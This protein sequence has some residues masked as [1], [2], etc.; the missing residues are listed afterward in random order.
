MMIL[1]LKK[2]NLEKELVEEILEKYKFIILNKRIL[3]KI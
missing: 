1:I 2:L 3:N